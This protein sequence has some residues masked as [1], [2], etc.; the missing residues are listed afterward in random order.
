MNAPLTETQDTEISNIAEEITG[1]LQTSFDVLIRRRDQQYADAIAPLDA[2]RDTLEQ[3][4]AF[5][6]VERVNLERLVPSLSRV[7]QSQADALLI[8]GK[9]EEA[10][11]KFAEAEEAANAPAAMTERQR[12]I[13]ARIEAIEREKKTIARRIFETWYADVQHIIRAAE[14][15]LF[16]TL[17]NGI[18]DS[19]IDFQARTGTTS[20][21]GLTGGLF[22]SGHV[23]GLTANDRSPE[24][25][26]ASRWYG[27]RGRR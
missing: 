18:E 11:A 20:P 3:E 8:A 19:M 1:N 24:W 23:V 4:S 13:S 2:E 17:L 16:V 10:Q 6:E 14:H 9:D 22:H 15:G 5:I 26:A 27:G 7:A 12:E 21:N 25:Q